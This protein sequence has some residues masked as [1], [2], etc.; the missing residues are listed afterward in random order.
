MT[1]RSVDQVPPLADVDPYPG[2]DLYYF[3]VIECG[4][5]ML[6]TVV[7]IFIKPHSPTQAA[8]ACIFALAS[9]L[10]FELLRPHMD[11]CLFVVV[12]TLN[13]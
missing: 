4:R 1:V 2:P 10:G 11:P 9:L 6:L 13:L 5:R 7:L 12:L 8:M 3:E